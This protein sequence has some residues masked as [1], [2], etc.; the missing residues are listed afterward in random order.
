MAIAG[1]PKLVVADEPTTALDVTVQAQ[2]LELIATL[3]AERSMSFVFITHDLAV[4]RRVADRIIVLYGGRIVEEGSTDAVLS[5]PVHPYSVGLLR[6]RVSLARCD[7]FVTGCR[8]CGRAARSDRRCHSGCA[9]APRCL[10][11]AR[12][13]AATT[14]SVL[15]LGVVGG[16][17][18]SPQHCLRLVT[19]VRTR[20]SRCHMREYEVALTAAAV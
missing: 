14:A 2:I 20:T 7:R 18:R 9:Y 10:N 15:R 19:A 4:A 12:D 13:R 16:P 8:P 6:S 11:R 1:N 3:R 17:L 5:A